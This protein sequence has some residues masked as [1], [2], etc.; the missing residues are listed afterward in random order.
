MER[1]VTF[2]NTSIGW[3]VSCDQNTGIIHPCFRERAFT[4]QKSLKLLPNA[5][6]VELYYREFIIATCLTTPQKWGTNMWL[7]HR[8]MIFSLVSPCLDH[9]NSLYSH[10]KLFSYLYHFF[11]Q[12]E[13]F[14]FIECGM[15]VWAWTY[16]KNLILHWGSCFNLIDISTGN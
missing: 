6:E 2:I 10:T 3:G 15:H 5:A 1:R 4:L 13:C 9:Q 12:S 16:Y 11:L 7:D 8:I 14:T